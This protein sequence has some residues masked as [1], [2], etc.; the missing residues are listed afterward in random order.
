MISLKKMRQ[1]LKRQLDVRSQAQD[2][3]VPLWQ[4]PAILFSLLGAIIMILMYLVYT[5]S[6]MSD[7]P[8]FLIAAEAVVV[9]SMLFVGGFF[10][11]AIEQIARA[12]KMKSEFIAIASHQMKSPLAQVKWLLNSIDF[13]SIEEK[14]RYQDKFGQLQKSNESMIQ[15]INDLLDVARI[16]RG[17]NIIRSGK[18]DIVGMAQTILEQYTPIAKQKNIE[19]QLKNNIGVG[20]KA[21]HTDERRIGVALDNLVRNAISYTKEEGHVEISLE[22]EGEKGFRICVKDNGIGVPESE[23]HRI[24]ERFFRASNGKKES[25]NGTGL[26]LY[27]TKSIVE[28]SGGTIWFRS[29]EG[30]GSMFCISLPITNK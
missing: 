9:M 13:S 15:L 14:N 30:A 16:D 1:Y 2:L 11:H 29:I 8:S 25:A 6:Q 20:A 26:G 24:F 19:I 4:A 17:E 3:G 27:L 28:Q 18:V 23:Q 7:D 10:I 5:S 12:N 21:V 22:K